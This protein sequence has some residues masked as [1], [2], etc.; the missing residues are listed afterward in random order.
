MTKDAY[1][2]GHRT[3]IC[4]AGGTVPCL[5]YCVIEVA[6]GRFRTNHILH[7]PLHPRLF[8]PQPTE[9]ESSPW[10]HKLSTFP[11]HAATS[12]PCPPPSTKNTAMNLDQQTHF[13]HV[14]HRHETAVL[15]RHHS[16]LASA[17]PSFL[18][19]PSQRRFVTI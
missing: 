6:V 10:T 13:R 3:V 12:S 9:D 11:T 2:G 5:A 16:I 14:S 1:Q 8:T 15:R 17:K 7:C 18:L 19:P 4:G